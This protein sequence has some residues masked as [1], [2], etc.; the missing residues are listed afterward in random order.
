MAC[1]PDPT[2]A[3]AAS[4]GKRAEEDFYYD[5]AFLVFTAAF[6]LKRGHCCGNACRHCPY[7]ANGKPVPGKG[8]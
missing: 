6:H 1:L 8:E 4:S 3:V 2:P 5:G 7:D